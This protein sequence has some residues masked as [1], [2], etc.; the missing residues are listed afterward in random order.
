[1]RVGASLRGR[2]LGSSTIECKGDY[3]TTAAAA[4]RFGELL[5]GAGRPGCF[6]PEDLF[7]LGDLTAALADSGLRVRHAP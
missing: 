7:G 4:R 2:E 3:R 6:N 5:A 1:M